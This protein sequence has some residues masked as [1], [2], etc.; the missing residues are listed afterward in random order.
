MGRGVEVCG[1]EGRMQRGRAV[2]EI[3]VCLFQH[4]EACSAA[5]AAAAYLESRATLG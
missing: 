2:A 3:L 4:T 5:A 1:R